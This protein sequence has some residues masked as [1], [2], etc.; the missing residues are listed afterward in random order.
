MLALVVDHVRL[1]KNFFRS[2]FYI[3][4]LIS[5]V[6]AGFIWTIMYNFSFGILNTL[7]HNLHL[8][9][10][11]TNWLGQSPNALISIIVVLV[12]QLAG[13]YMI[14]YLAALQGIPTELVEAAK[15]DGA[16]VFDRFKNITL[17]LMAG[18]FTINLTLALIAGLKVFDQIAVMTDGGPGFD[19][20]TLT[21]LI[22]KVAFGDLK[23][24]YG[25]ALAMTLFAIIMILGIFQIKFLRG[26]EVQM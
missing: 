3:P 10:L 15:I 21:Y 24:G 9:F 17:P 7:F 18:A 20:E 2:A 5:G 4:V 16:S 22:Y 11:K 1:G 8:D 14:I 25:T 13:Y 23:Q 12:W 19:T 26:K 6:I